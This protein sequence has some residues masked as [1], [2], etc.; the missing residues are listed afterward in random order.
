VTS[1]IGFRLRSPERVYTH[2]VN[3]QYPYFVYVEESEDRARQSILSHLLA[4]EASSLWYLHR[5][6]IC[7]ELAA[8]NRTGNVRCRVALLQQSESHPTFDSILRP[9]VRLFV[10]RSILYVG[11]SG[12]SY[13]LDV[14]IRDEN[15]TRSIA[16]VVGINNHM[17]YPLSDIRLPRSRTL[18]TRFAIQSYFQKAQISAAAA[19]TDLTS[20]FAVACAVHAARSDL[21]F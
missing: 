19:F 9:R 20:R 7:C 13:D 14:N 6:F 5:C 21:L 18:V 4:L 1:A 15:S 17:L 16:T 2:V 8:S 3:D 11:H 12:Q 10:S